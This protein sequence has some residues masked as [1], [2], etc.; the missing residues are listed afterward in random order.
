MP[1]IIRGTLPNQ[2]PIR[3]AT[4]QRPDAY[5]HATPPVNVRGHVN[6][7]RTGQ[8]TLQFASAGS[9]F[10]P[11]GALIGAGVG[12]ASDLFQVRIARKNAE[13]ANEEAKKAAAEQAARAHAE[14]VSARNYNSEQEQ[15]R[16]MRMAGLSPG[17]AYGQMSPST[18]QPASPEKADINKADTPKFDNES[19]LRALELLVKQQQA[20]TQLAAQQSTAGLQ[21][22]QTQ[23][24]LIDALTRNESN[25]ANIRGVL[26]SSSLNDAQKLEVLTL[27]FGKKENLDANTR[28]ILANARVTEGTGIPLAQSEIA[29]NKASASLN[30]QQEKVIKLTYDLDNAQWNSI[31]NFMKDNGIDESFAPIVMKAINSIVEQTGSTV[32]SVIDN[33]S[34]FPD[35][36][37]AF[38]S[39][40]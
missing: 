28:N 22:S 36:I 31:K 1:D 6:G 17:L 15:I 37:K 11:Y 30:A 2:I 10:G 18:A 39:G 12:L 9:A 23:L 34:K 33:L 14:S 8:N 26:S 35:I 40:M 16:R 27:L 19:I 21:G 20:D 24:N 38:I 7:H 5:N 4:I 3:P 13:K 29:A 25:L 32:K